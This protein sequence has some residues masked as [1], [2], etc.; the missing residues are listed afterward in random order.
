MS[1]SPTQNLDAMYQLMSQ[2]KGKPNASPLY[3]QV[4][5]PDAQ[6]AP[7]MRFDRH[8]NQDL[9]SDSL[10]FKSL[11]AFM[12]CV[13]RNSSAELT[14]AQMEKVCATEYKNLRLRAF[15]TQLMYHNVN[16]QHFVNELAMFK[17]ESPY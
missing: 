13:E 3:F 15:D 4:R 7:L 10:Y 1:E 6:N 2:L 11:N 5:N 8:F 17:H 16:K 12:S 9:A 14:D